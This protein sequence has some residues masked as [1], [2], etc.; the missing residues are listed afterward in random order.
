MMLD[1]LLIHMLIAT[2]SQSNE[3]L[4][5]RISQKTKIIIVVLSVFVAKEDMT[6]KFW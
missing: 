4:L 5:S 1:L 3:G 2:K 6:N